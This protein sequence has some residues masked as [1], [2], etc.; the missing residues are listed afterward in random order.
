VTL[1]PLGTCVILRKARSTA[2]AESRANPQ[3]PGPDTSVIL[4]KALRAADAES[5]ANPQL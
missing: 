1:R 2:D 3:L 5:R 4:R